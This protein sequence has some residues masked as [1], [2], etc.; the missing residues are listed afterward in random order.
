MLLERGKEEY[1]HDLSGDY[2]P[3]TFTYMMSCN[4]HFKGKK[5][6][7][8]EEGKVRLSPDMPDS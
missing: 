1:Y 7:V 4:L 8:R 5:Q 3:C 6:K 2:V